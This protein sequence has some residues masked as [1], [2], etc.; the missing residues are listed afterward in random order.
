ME[1]RMKVE[2]K[3]EGKQLKSVGVSSKITE[4]QNI[5]L[6]T[7][8]EEKGITKSNLIG[9]LLEMGYKQATKRIF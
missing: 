7:L 6:K 2:R 8:A 4:K 3:I 1:C 9:Q 5:K